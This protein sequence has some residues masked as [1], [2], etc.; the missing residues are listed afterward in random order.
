MTAAQPSLK[1]MAYSMAFVLGILKDQSE[2]KQLK[3]CPTLKAED[4]RLL[5]YSVVCLDAIYEK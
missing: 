3:K 1:G 5:V 4:D 2:I